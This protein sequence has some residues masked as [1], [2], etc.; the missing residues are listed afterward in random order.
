MG[1]MVIVALVAALLA[2][3]YIRGR[4]IPSKGRSA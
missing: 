1:L 3:G 4:G 2:G